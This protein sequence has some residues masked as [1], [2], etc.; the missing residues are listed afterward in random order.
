MEVEAIRT[1]WQFVSTDWY[2]VALAGVSG[3]GALLGLA[4]SL[5]ASAGG[6]GGGAADSE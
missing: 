2:V 5:F 6:A 1:F 4:I 3:S